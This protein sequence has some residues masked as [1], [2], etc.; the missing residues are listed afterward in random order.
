M[1]NLKTPQSSPV[2]VH[3]LL[4]QA[5]D[6]KDQLQKSVNER[7]DDFRRAEKRRAAL[8]NDPVS[9]EEY[10]VRLQQSIQLRADNWLENK[11]RFVIHGKDSLTDPLTRQRGAALFSSAW[12]DFGAICAGA[13]DLAEAIVRAITERVGYTPGPPADVRA[14]QLEM[15][16]REVE[17]LGREHEELVDL[18][19]AAGLPMK[20]RPEVVQRRELEARRQELAR[21]RHERLRVVQESI[22]QRERD[23]DRV[24]DSRP[25]GRT[26]RSSY[27]GR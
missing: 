9:Q 26:G 17:Q 7:F 20:H 4:R 13:P 22:D 23:L 2:D 12:D 27:L 24:T 5:T 11:G 1:S 18:A 15:A 19:V 10:D 14:A 25:G 21:E 16:D 6:A 8:V 3:E